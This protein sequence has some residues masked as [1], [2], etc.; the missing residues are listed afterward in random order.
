M[1]E[2]LRGVQGERQEITPGHTP[3]RWVPRAS[4]PPAP[5]QRQIWPMCPL[6]RRARPSWRPRPRRWCAPQLCSCCVRHVE[7]RVLSRACRMGVA[8]LRSQAGM[9]KKHW[10]AVLACGFGMWCA[11]IPCL[12]LCSSSCGCGQSPPDTA[13][14]HAT[15]TRC[16]ADGHSWQW[17]QPVVSDDLWLHHNARVLSPIWEPPAASAASAASAE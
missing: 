9:V 13:W 8:R 5:F 14:L 7:P 6:P 11:C 1:P 15:T 16:I 10:H 12:C 4:L 3:K 17:R 2:D